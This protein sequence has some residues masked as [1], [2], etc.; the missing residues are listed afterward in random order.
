ME[1][2]FVR[3]VA[4]VEDAVTFPSSFSTEADPASLVQITCRKTFGCQRN[5][6]K[7]CFENCQDLDHNFSSPGQDPAEPVPQQRFCSK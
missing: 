6:L 1:S 5:L 3:S 2:S 7:V 4:L